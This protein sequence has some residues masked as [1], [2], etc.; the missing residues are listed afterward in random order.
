MHRLHI[1]DLVKGNKVVKKEV[2]NCY[3]FSFV[4][5]FTNR[6]IRRVLLDEIAPASIEPP[7]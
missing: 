2:A 3:S 4:Q 5:P 6:D 7:Y 1:I